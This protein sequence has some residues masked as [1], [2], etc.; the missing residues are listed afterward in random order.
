MNTHNIVLPC[1]SW[2]SELAKTLKRLETTLIEALNEKGL[3]LDC[4]YGSKS[5]LIFGQN[6]FGIPLNASKIKNNS[7]HMLVPVLMTANSTIQKQISD[8]GLLVACH[9]VLVNECKTFES[10]EVFVL[11]NELVREIRKRL[12][13]W[14]DNLNEWK[15]N[16]YINK[17]MAIVSA[18][19]NYKKILVIAKNT[20]QYDSTEYNITDNESMESLQSRILIQ[21]SNV[22]KALNDLN[23]RLTTDDCTTQEEKAV[24]EV[25]TILIPLVQKTLLELKKYENALEPA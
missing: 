17:W 18:A 10:N 20:I 13:V 3:R 25:K 11:I 2:N 22:I 8:A 9:D 12:K 23:E 5:Q 1:S 24:V 21:K 19:Y 6:H 16:K 14:M 4:G 15:G 7:F